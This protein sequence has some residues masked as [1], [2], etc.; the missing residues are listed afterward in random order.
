M[1]VGFSSVH[2]GQLKAHAAQHPKVGGLHSFIR[3]CR[4]FLGR[5]LMSDEDGYEVGWGRPPK[6]SRWP[7]TVSGN[8]IG[9]PKEGRRGLCQELLKEGDRLRQ[10]EL[11]GKK[12]KMT[13]REIAVRLTYQDATSDVDSPKAFATMLRAF[14]TILKYEG[15]ELDRMI[16]A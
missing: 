8:R 1:S 12:Y 4:P 9:R 7:K 13:N 2:V 5:Q 15:E 16:A 6:H 11:D 3:E 14:S 10:F